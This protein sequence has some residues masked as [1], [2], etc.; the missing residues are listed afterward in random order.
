[1][2]AG[3]PAMAWWKLAQAWGVLR[4]DEHHGLGSERSR[5][6]EFGFSGDFEQSKTT[7][8]DKPVCLRPVTIGVDVWV[9]ERTLAK[10]APRARSYHMPTPADG[11]WSATRRVP[12]SGC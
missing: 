9:G 1:M 2:D 7:R 4:H 10:L 11:G 5:L 12:A 8:P 3:Q 6:Y